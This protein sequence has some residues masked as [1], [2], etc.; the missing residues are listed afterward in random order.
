ML[1]TGIIA[2]SMGVTLAGDSAS[3]YKWHIT[4]G[5]GSVADDGA[6]GGECG[7][8]VA[9]RQIGT[10]V[11]VADRAGERF[12]A[13]PSALGCYVATCRVGAPFWRL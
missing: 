4:A 2:R 13:L 8:S 12:K 10:W 1:V 6:G 3:G 11:E 7:V 5:G 9:V